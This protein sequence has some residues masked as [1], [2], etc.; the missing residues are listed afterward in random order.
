MVSKHKS[1]DLRHTEDT[2]VVTE[3]NIANQ[4]NIEDI[5]DEEEGE[6][7]QEKENR[8]PHQEGILRPLTELEAQAE[9]E[10]RQHLDENQANLRNIYIR[11]RY[12]LLENIQ[13]GVNIPPLTRN[14]KRKLTTQLYSLFINDINPTLERM[15]PTPEDEY[16]W[17]AFE[18]VYEDA[19]DKIRQI[20]VQMK[21]RQLRQLY[22]AR[23]INTK[24][25]ASRERTNESLL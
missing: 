3:I 7:E 20:I 22:G 15:M 16:S 14:D 2:A 5:E 19:M 18:C 24:L 17:L 6:D 23:I 25:Q 1:N 12:A 11:K 10:R 8:Y 4:E 21:G 9:S 13:A